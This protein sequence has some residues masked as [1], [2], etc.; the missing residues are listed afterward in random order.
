V[1]GQT[2]RAIQFTARKGGGNKN[3]R[4]GNSLVKPKWANDV[5]IYVRAMVL[6]GPNLFVAG[7]PDMID[8]EQTFELISKSDPNV[9]KLLSEQDDALLGKQGA[10]L[11]GVDIATGTIQN[12]IPLEALP[13][14]D[15]MAGANGRLFLSTLDGKIHC[16][17]N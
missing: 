11:I 17:G 10:M 8:E 9:E 3:N 2:G 16:Y 4:Q 5:P 6:S 7:P 1:E 12:N 15:G 13:A 14:W